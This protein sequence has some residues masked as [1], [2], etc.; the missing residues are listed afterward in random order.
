[1]VSKPLLLGLSA[2]VISGFSYAR[3]QNNE[4]FLTSVESRFQ[5]S[6]LKNPQSSSLSRAM[7]KNIRNQILRNE[8]STLSDWNRIQSFS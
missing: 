5:E 8:F 6:P 1:M 3:K 2:S 7:V 4:G